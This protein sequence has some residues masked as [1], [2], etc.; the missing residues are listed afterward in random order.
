MFIAGMALAFSEHLTHFNRLLFRQLKHISEMAS[1]DVPAEPEREILS[2][3][4]TIVQQKQ[5]L[6]D[7]LLQKWKL[8][9]HD[10]YTPKDLA[11]K[12][13]F[14]RAVGYAMRG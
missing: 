12:G 2:S 6:F 5:R 4:G 7:S 10:S 14:C 1:E 13:K 3:H 8:R 11:D 9:V